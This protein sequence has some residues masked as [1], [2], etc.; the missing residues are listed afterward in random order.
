LVGNEA[1]RGRP[2]NLV[3][4][5]ARWGD[6]AVIAA[7]IMK[8]RPEINLSSPAEPK[9]TFDVSA[10]RSLPGVRLDRGHGGIRAHLEELVAAMTKAKLI[11]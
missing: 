3:D 10:A 11:G 7:E 6:W 8:I 1:A 9:N 4:C 5:Y 2:F